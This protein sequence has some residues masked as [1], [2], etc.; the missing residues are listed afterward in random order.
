MPRGAAH[1]SQYF[2]NVK[3]LRDE[4][5]SAFLDGLHRELQRALRRHRND[6]G[7]GTKSAELAH[8]FNP[9]D[10]GHENVSQHY[11]EFFSPAESYGF[12][13]TR[14]RRH[15]VPAKAE[16]RLQRHARATLVV[17]D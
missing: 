5:E 4:I 3:G 17:N 9:G 6:L 8:Y 12:A 11:I 7:L 16:R 14:R 2:V 13:T 15:V 1:Q 10:V